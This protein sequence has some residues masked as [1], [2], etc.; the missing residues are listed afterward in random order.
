MKGI[1]ETIELSGRQ[2]EICRKPRK[3][4]IAMTMQV[5]G[6][7]RVSTSLST[8]LTYIRQF[9]LQNQT[10][11]ENQEKSYQK[12]REL[13]PVKTYCEGESFYFLGKPTPLHYKMAVGSRMK[14]S[15][16]LESGFVCQIPAELWRRFDPLQ[17]HPEMASLFKKFYERAGRDLLAQS[18][19]KFSVAMNLHPKALSFRSQKTRW[20]SCSSRGKLSLNWRLAFAPREVIDYVVVHE[21]AHLKHYNHS[22]AFWSLVGSQISDYRTWRKWLRAHQ[23]EA[24]FLGRR[25]ELHL[26][27]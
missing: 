25:S 14:F 16:S 4:N 3:R 6:R 10:W 27:V 20:G 15:Q 13:F 17:P 12:I 26:S 19:Q 11:I 21:L 7:L 5:S 1:I 18:V 23:Y 8:P 9:V 2:I 22:A 24:D